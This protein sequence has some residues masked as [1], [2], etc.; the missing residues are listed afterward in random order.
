MVPGPVSVVLE[1]WHTE[2]H[3]LALYR[4]GYITNLRESLVLITDLE[5]P[6]STIR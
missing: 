3:E 2:P 1:R 5:L 4:L 6:L